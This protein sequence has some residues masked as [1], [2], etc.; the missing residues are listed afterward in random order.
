[1]SNV[2][3][4]IHKVYQDGLQEAMKFSIQEKDNLCVFGPSGGGKTAMALQC[5]EEE[6]CNAVYINLSVLERPDFQ[7]W[8]APAQG[9]LIAS[10]AT[11]EFLPFED[12]KY[13]MQRKALDKLKACYKPGDIQGGELIDL[14]EKRL[15][16][17]E[18]Y[19]KMIALKK[20]LP[21]VEGD[22]NITNA[23][24]QQLGQIEKTGDGLGSQRPNVLLF[25]EADKAP[26][27]VLQPL[28][29]V[30]QLH[31]VNGRPLNIQSCFLL[32]N[33]PD[34]GA[35][36]EN[37]S[38][39]LTKRC[40]VLR[41]ELAFDQWRKWAFKKDVHPLI[42]GFIASESSLLHNTETAKNDP[43]AY[44]APTP[45]SW[46]YASNTLYACE[47]KKMNLFDEKAGG[48]DERKSSNSITTSLIAS[49]VGLHAALK[50]ENWVKYYHE[51][52]PTIESIAM[53][54]MQIGPELSFDQQL[55]VALGACTRVKRFLNEDDR[56][57]CVKTAKNVFTWLK[58]C[59]TEVQIG[60]IRGAFDWEEVK[61]YKLTDIP[62]VQ[63]VVDTLTDRLS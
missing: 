14:I 23:I 7:G 58:G 30:T 51:L 6:G 35:H 62:E 10:Y 21:Y 63:K 13:Y 42:I 27:E 4:D 46:E 48:D 41:L 43:T 57:D 54:G 16:G 40:K 9:E 38:H 2:L 45:R 15:S 11:P 32:C 61:D 34:E 25:D 47:K 5:I 60:A 20:A 33:L 49:H 39:A 59:S 50:L 29:E 18:V 3:T 24:V 53:K 31:T 22:K 12:T 19:D 36:S 52:D 1:M 26:H 17:I 44:A 37:L 56:D 28:L 8:P 55:V